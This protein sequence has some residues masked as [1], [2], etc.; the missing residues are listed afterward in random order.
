MTDTTGD[1]GQHSQLA[2]YANDG[3]GIYGLF[4]DGGA[5]LTNADLDACHGHVGTVTWNGSPQPIYHYHM[6]GEYPYT[7]GCFKGRPAV[8]DQ[9][10]GAGPGPR[11]GRR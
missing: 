8:R 7:L 9:G 5:R 6:T 2:G 1:S 11:E 10:R 4:G 3:F